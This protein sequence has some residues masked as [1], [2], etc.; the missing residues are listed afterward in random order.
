M[1]LTAP[2]DL[3]VIQEIRDL[4]DPKEIEAILAQMA[5][6]EHKDRRG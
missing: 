5:L 6:T 3:K 4:R 1:E 2:R